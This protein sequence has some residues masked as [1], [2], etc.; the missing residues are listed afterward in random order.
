VRGDELFQCRWVWVGIR[1]SDGVGGPEFKAGVIFVD[2]ECTFSTFSISSF[3]RQRTR[4][5]P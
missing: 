4:G 5:V 2:I 1:D 3:V